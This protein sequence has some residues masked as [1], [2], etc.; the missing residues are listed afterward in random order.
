MTTDT[1]HPAELDQSGRTAFTTG[2]PFDW[3]QPHAWQQ[4]WIAAAESAQR[5]SGA[6]RH[7]PAA[8]TAMRAAYVVLKAMPTSRM[9]FDRQRELERAMIG[10]GTSIA[11]LGTTGGQ[12]EGTPAG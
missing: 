11:Q 5:R 10:L 1:R 8:V 7:V 9:R 3:A 4:G 12:V 6:L 2:Q